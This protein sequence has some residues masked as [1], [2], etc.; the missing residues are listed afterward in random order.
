MLPLPSAACFARAGICSL[1]LAVAGAAAQPSS[2]LRLAEVRGSE[3]VLLEKL[4]AATR[5]KRHADALELVVRLL[6]SDSPGVVAVGED[7]YVGLWEYCQRVLA[8]LPAEMLQQYRQ[9]TDATAAQ[10]YRQAIAN[11]DSRKLQQLLDQMFCSSWGDDAL[12]ALGELALERG[13]YQ[14]ARTAWQ[15]IGEA[16]PDTDLDLAMVAARLTLLSIREG[17]FTQ[18]K[19]QL[20]SLQKNHPAVHGRMAGRDVVFTEYLTALLEQSSDD[21]PSMPVARNYQKL[22]SHS[23]KT[24][25]TLVHPTVV[26]ELLIFQDATEVHALHLATGKPALVENGTVLPAAR[27]T[28]GRAWHRLAA[29]DRYV[30]GA[31][32][33][34]LWGIDLA[35]D[36]ALFFQRKF[37]P[38]QATFAGPPAMAD[39]RVLV[40]LRSGNRSIGAS[41]ACY[42]PA[43]KKLQWKK[44]LCQR[45]TSR[46]KPT[47]A[48]AAQVLAIDSGIAYLST[49]LGIVGAVRVWDGRVLWLHSY[50]QNAS[51]NSNVCLYH[52]GVV[53]VAPSD[54]RQILALNAATGQ[55]LWST[56]NQNPTACVF[57]HNQ[58]IQIGNQQLDLQTGHPNPHW[59]NPKQTSKGQGVLDGATLLWPTDRQIEQ[60]NA[61]TGQTLAPP[62]DLSQPGG[63]N[64]S[65]TGNYLIAASPTELTVFSATEKEPIISPPH[66]QEK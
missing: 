34:E 21:Q 38:N 31:K 39:S 1:M 7:C 18:A 62:I 11:R 50:K 28:E 10:W 53:L 32:R 12:L 40:P 37:K 29:T 46:A 24:N 44:S 4:T 63:A 20:T 2:D 54:S 49:N 8:Q 25:G 9:Q 52:Q 26:G 16:Y 13:D 45:M 59:K 55:R 60:L 51:G 23:L 30:F 35:R 57:A 14:S 19:S 17:N 41:L 66:P 36:G 47:S 6:Q 27:P 61:R 22:W 15:R 43:R 3:R 33:S 65:L 58:K 48:Q 5:E 64:L 42:D 56:K